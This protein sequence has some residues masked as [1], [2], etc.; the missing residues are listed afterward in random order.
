MSVIYVNT[1]AT[2]KNNGSS[3][4]NAYTNLQDAIDDSSFED[5]IW[6]SKGNYKPTENA[7]REVSFVLKDNISLYGG[8]EGIETSLE[9]RDWK[10][11]VTVLDGDIGIVGDN[12]DNSYNLIYANSIENSI[13][14]GFSVVNGNASDENDVAIA[15]AGVFIQNSRIALENLTFKGNNAEIGGAIFSLNSL[16]QYTDILLENNFAGVS[17]GGIYNSNSNSNFANLSFKNNF[18]QEDGAG[19]YNEESNIILNKVAFEGNESFRRGGAIYNYLNSRV[20]INRGFFKDNSSETE[21]GAIFNAYNGT[22][23]IDRSQFSFNNAGFSGGAIYNLEDDSISTISNS[24]FDFN[25]ARRGGAVHNYRSSSI[26][27]NNTFVNNSAEVEGSALFSVGIN[28]N[29]QISNS[30]IYDNNS[31]DVKT[32]FDDLSSTEISFSAFEEGFNGLGNTDETPLFIDLENGNYRLNKNSPGVDSGDNISNNNLED[33]AGRQRVFNDL[34]DM[35]AYEFVAPIITIDDIEVSLRNSDRAKLTIRLI[36]SNGRAFISEERV[37]VDFAT[38]DGTAYSNENYVAKSDTLVFNPGEMEK[39]IEIVL[40]TEALIDDEAKFS[41]V[42]DEAKNALIE[43]DTA[44]VVINDDLLNTPIYR[45]QNLGQPGTYLYVG[46]EE[47]RAIRRSNPNFIEE[48]LAFKVG[49][50]PGENL[51][52]LYR[53]QSKSVPGTY[54]FVGEEERESINDNYNESFTEEGLAFYVYGIDSSLGTEFSR[55]QNS[56]RPGTY[57]FATGEERENIRENFS[58]F[59]EEGLAFEVN[60]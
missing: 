18:S 56:D 54:L 15:G 34:V 2:G 55:F 1:E 53:F 38:E 5:E 8:F 50:E 43:K 59:I 9:Q 36:D 28:T 6:V 44:D 48:G 29:P 12:R 23:E 32:V 58:N 19:I 22:L 46:E 35:G 7:D 11:N 27:I 4:L 10:N 39:T 40:N 42:L 21:G 13:I 37:T 60:I 16:V 41:V 24:V 49:E 33:F 57:L 17:G 47:R 3:W 14:D 30:I 20:D 52:S 51:I 25:R 26:F 31:S 45:F